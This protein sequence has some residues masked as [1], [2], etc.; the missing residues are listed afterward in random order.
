MRSTAS[1]SRRRAAACAAVASV[2]AVTAL[3]AGWTRAQAPETT[4]AAGASPEAVAR[5]PEAAVARAANPFRDRFPDVVLK[6]H[7]G[8]NVRFYDD[9]LKGK[10]VLINFM[11]ATCQER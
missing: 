10:I 1:R 9:L 2:A 3:G 4:A 5:A 11:Y 7:E 6:T 8:K